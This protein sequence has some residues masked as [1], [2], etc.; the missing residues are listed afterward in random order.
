L[1][2]ITYRLAVIIII[3]DSQHATVDRIM[4]PAGPLAKQRGGDGAALSTKQKIIFVDDTIITYIVL[5][6]GALF[7]R[8][9]R[10]LIMIAS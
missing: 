8:Q 3:H 10:S 5:F 2:A 4:L 6:I 9:V 1:L 7:N